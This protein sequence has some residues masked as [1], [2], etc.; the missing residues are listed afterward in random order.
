MDFKDTKGPQ[1]T[2]GGV[3]K[4]HKIIIL[5]L[6]PSSGDPDNCFYVKNGGKS[7]FLRRINNSANETI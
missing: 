7:I 5:E 4:I 3:L 6:L 1:K 2:Y